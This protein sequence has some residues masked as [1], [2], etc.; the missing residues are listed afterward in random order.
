MVGEWEFVVEVVA[1]EFV[2]APPD[3]AAEPV[4]ELVVVLVEVA[5]LAAFSVPVIEGAAVFTAVLEVSIAATFVEDPTAA[6]PVPVAAVSPVAPFV[7]D[8]EGVFDVAPLVVSD[9]AAA[10]L[11]GAFEATG[12]EE[13]AVPDP[14]VAAT[15]VAV[16]A[17]SA[18][19]ELCGLGVAAAAVLAEGVT[20]LLDPEVTAGALEASAVDGPG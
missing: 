15:G 17:E 4:A 9:T 20:E 14:V 7:E 5:A 12:V 11:G 10:A 6:E 19:V 18:A 3:I 16:T 8:V 1:W 13:A 2:V